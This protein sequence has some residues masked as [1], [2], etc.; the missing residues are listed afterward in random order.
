MRRLLPVYAAEA[1]ARITELPV[2]HRPRTYGKSKYSL[3]ASSRVLLDL[4]AV[5]LVG[6]SPRPVY[7]LGVAAAGAWLLAL[8]AGVVVA[9]QRVV[10]PY[11]HVHANLLVVAAVGL[12]IIG[13]QLFLAALTIQRS[14]PTYVVRE[15]IARPPHRQ[16]GPMERTAGRATLR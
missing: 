12:A 13:V 9:V 1:G 15:V 10:P 2:N 3:A 11:V 7:L 16:P 4:V 8:A 5:K 6:G 14:E